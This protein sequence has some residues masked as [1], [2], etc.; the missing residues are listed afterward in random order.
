MDDTGMQPPDRRCPREPLGLAGRRRTRRGGRSRGPGPRGCDAADGGDRRGPAGRRRP[1]EF[2]D[3]PPPPLAPRGCSSPLT[4]AVPWMRSQTKG[5]TIREARHH[6]ARG[7]RLVRRPLALLVRP[8]P[9]PEPDGRRRVAGLQRRP[10]RAR[11]R[12]A[13]PPPPGHRVAD[14]RRRGP[15]PPR[16]LA[17]QQRPARAGRRPGHDVLARR[18]PALGEERLPRRA[19]A[20]H[21]VLDPAQHPRP[22][23][24]RPAAAAHA[25][26]A[27]RP[28]APDHGPGR[29]RRPRALAGRPGP[30]LAP[31]R[32]RSSSTSSDRAGAAIST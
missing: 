10:D 19:D 23:D 14:V 24:A 27:D 25:R 22:R 16:R 11:R 18:R 28:L 4:G 15:L 1:R 30:C 20:V 5:V 17:R 3:R 8:L 9:G 21:P 7:G 32:E 6:L 31:D 13:A 12:V 29:H 26:G 2:T